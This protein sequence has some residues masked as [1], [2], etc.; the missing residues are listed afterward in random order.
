MKQEKKKPMTDTAYT[1]SSD[2]GRPVLFYCFL[3]LVAWLPLPLGSNRPWAW[4]I[5]EIGSFALL[6]LW[7]AAHWRAKGP[8]SKALESARIPLTALGL[9]LVSFLLQVIPLPSGLSELLS[10]ASFAI[11]QFNSEGTRLLV[12]SVSLDKG[13]TL[14]A[15]L[16]ASS[17]S[18][19]FFLTLVLADTHQKVKTMVRVMVLTGFGTALYGLI[20]TLTGIEYI[21]WTP[22]EYYK[23]FVTGTFINKNHFAGF[24]EITIPLGIAILMTDFHFASR[25]KD[26]FMDRAKKVMVSLLDKR[27]RM[28]AYVV[29]MFSALFL[30]SSRAGVA[31]FFTAMF[32]A[33]L[34]ISSMKTS[35]ERERMLAPVV[36]VLALLSVI[37]LGLGS[38][39]GRIAE[40]ELSFAGRTQA[41][42]GSINAINDFFPLGA[43]AGA[44]QW[45]YPMY[46]TEGYTRVYF[47]HAHN[48]YIEILVDQGVFGLIP[49]LI[50]FFSAQRRLYRG[51]KQR[52]DP[53]IRGAIFAA[54]AGSLS[55]A[56]HGLIDFNFQIPA[57]AAYFFMTLALGIAAGSL[58]SRR[59]ALAKSD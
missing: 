39:P 6:G 3:A 58:K 14:S 17:Y 27:G 33:G 4:S 30:S 55:L 47:D 56:I 34:T 29:I 52:R 32:I 13:A 57:N 20:M 23:G 51:L 42:E 24:M 36:I 15:L 54:A 26:T 46:E 25:P 50:F 35:R 8:A 18:A 11:Q 21:W 12:T 28:A 45:I 59:N 22:K 38:L 1:N 9:W 5:M 41:W 48:D 40:S 2:E 53:M 7:M 10:P 49:L 44:F 43:G 16:K 37:W 31:S 19:L